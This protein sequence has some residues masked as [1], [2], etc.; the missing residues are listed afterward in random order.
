[1]FKD[2]YASLDPIFY[3][4]INPVP[5]SKPSLVLYNNELAQQF[6]LNLKH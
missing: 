1:M 5:V 3:E 4:V 2:I 6:K